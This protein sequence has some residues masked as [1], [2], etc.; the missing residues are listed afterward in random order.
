MRTHYERTLRCFEFY[1]RSPA[2]LADAASA[3]LPPSDEN[4]T[5]PQLRDRW[6]KVRAAAPQYAAFR[7]YPAWQSF[8]A[9]ANTALAAVGLSVPDAAPAE[10]PDT[11]QPAQAHTDAAA[12]PDMAHA[13]DDSAAAAAQVATGAPADGA[14]AKG[15]AVWRKW[16]GHGWFEG[17]V[18]EFNPNRGPSGEH[19][20]SYKQGA[21]GLGELTERFDALNPPV[22][23]SWVNPKP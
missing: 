15:R 1:M 2:A 19:T 6:Q 18:T 16:E 7:A 20:I 23:L 22:P 4:L 21:T 9:D 8:A 10:N 14:A 17:R 12:Q 11:G 5:R 3:A 13:A